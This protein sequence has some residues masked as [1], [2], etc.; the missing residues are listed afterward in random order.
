MSL[1]ILFF[2]LVMMTG[3]SSCE[4]EFHLL[5]N[6]QECSEEEPSD[7]YIRVDLPYAPHPQASITQLRVYNGPT[8]EYPLIKTFTPS[9]GGTVNINI[10]LNRTYTFEAI[11]FIEGQTYRAITSKRPE[12]KFTER[13]C[14]N[15][16][17]YIVNTKINLELKY[18]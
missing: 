17:Y 7:A 11:Y 6:C 15:P 16:C 12:V 14:E 10:T 5:V 13:M 4:E 1:R 9:W 3:L 18:N 8:N 2:S